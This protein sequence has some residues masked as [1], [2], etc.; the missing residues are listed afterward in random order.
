MYETS[1]STA[2]DDW[3]YI[4]LSYFFFYYLP[5]VY[6]TFFP[7]PTFLKKLFKVFK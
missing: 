3:L 4:L 2:I 5:N 7:A 1:L 6:V